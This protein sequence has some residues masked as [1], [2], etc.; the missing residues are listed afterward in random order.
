MMII[1]GIAATIAALVGYVKW[2]D[3]RNGVSLVDPSESSKAVVQA[4][5][6][7]AQDVRQDEAWGA[8]RI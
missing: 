2:H 4:D 5:R 6:Q 3:R 8:L 1:G 7:A